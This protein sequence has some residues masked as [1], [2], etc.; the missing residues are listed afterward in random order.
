MKKSL[1][2]G[3]AIVGLVVGGGFAS[4][5]EI[6]QFF[7]SFGYYGIL[8]AIIATFG[9]AFFG[10]NIAQLGYQLGTTSHKEVLHYISGRTI[11][12]ILDILITFFLFCVTVAMFA[13]TAS[14][15]RQVLGID[16]VLGSV[17]MVG[18]TIF[19]LMLNTKSIINVIAI[20]TPYLL[21]FMLL[22][23][24][25]SILSMDLTLSEQVSLA[26][27]QPSAA[28]N[29]YMG[30]LL[31]I[32]Y[33][34]ASAL[35]MIIVIGSTATSKKT[36]GW[37]G[38]FGGV[39][40]GILILLINAAMFAK[41]DV[42]SGKDMPILE[43]ARDIH[44]LIGFIMALGLVGMIYSTAVGMM[45]S[46]INRLVSPKD[47]VYKPTVVLFGIIGFMASFVGFTNLVSKVYSIMGYLGFVLIVAVFFSWLKRK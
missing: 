3:G 16:P 7:T 6:M 18:L 10:M 25:Y 37:G 11:G 9:L 27:R 39:L 12:T 36:A 4:G 47:K 20:A 31:Y 40:L 29:W 14:I 45:Y 1:Q 2:I 26:E 33:N 34:I 24:L 21:A 8:G 19:T 28:P 46:F 22:I 38:I 43:I 13:G 30:S 41:M 15:F 35:S 44:P 32:S 23:A 17:F 42:V 5:Q